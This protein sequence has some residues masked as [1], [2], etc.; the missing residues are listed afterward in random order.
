MNTQITSKE[1]RHDG[2]IEG[3][4][5]LTQKRAYELYLKRGQKPGH[6]LEDWLQA[7]RDISGRKEHLGPY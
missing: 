4:A 7:E 6:E 1:T 2:N 3:K 5:Q